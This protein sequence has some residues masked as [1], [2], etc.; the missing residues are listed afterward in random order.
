MKF[1]LSF[2]KLK[3]LLLTTFLLLS[4]ISFAQVANDDISKSLAKLENI[5]GTMYQTLLSIE[6]HQQVKA[7][8]LKMIELAR[9]TKLSAKQLTEII[10]KSNDVKLKSETESDLKEIIRESDNAILYSNNALNAENDDFRMHPIDYLNSSVKD[11]FNATKLLM[12]YINTYHFNEH[13]N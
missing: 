5:S 6:Q 10:E 13:N 4:L 8:L 9:Q 2:R 1:T 12:D 3:H 11:V 7:D